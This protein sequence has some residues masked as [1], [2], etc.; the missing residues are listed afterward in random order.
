MRL[1]W[2][3][4]HVVVVVVVVVLVVPFVLSPHCIVECKAPLSAHPSS[5]TYLPILFPDRP[6]V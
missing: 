5:S 4:P 2:E 3:H 1:Q 6:C